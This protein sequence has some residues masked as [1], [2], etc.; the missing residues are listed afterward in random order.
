LFPLKIAEEAGVVQIEACEIILLRYNYACQDAN[1]VD[2]FFCRREC[3][4]MNKR[5]SFGGYCQNGKC[6][7]YGTKQC[8]WTYQYN[9]TI[10]FLVWNYIIYYRDSCILFNVHE[11]NSNLII[12]K[13]Y[14][15][16]L[17]ISFLIGKKRINYSLGL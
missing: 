12:I 10:F 17:I 4:V 6:M 2:M 16:Y 8:I 13:K 1:F 5:L 11:I 15:F 7:C 9:Y 3:R 14:I